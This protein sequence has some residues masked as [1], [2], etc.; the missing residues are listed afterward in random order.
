VNK[1]SDILLRS[2]NAKKVIPAVDALS[3]DGGRKNISL[4]NSRSLLID[5]IRLTESL[6]VHIKNAVLFIRTL[7]CLV[8]LVLGGIRDGQKSLPGHGVRLHTR[9]NKSREFLQTSNFPLIWGLMARNAPV[10]STYDGDRAAIIICL[11]LLLVLKPGS[12]PCYGTLGFKMASTLRTQILNHLRTPLQNLS[13]L[14]IKL[15]LSQRLVGRSLEPL[16]I[17]VVV[18]NVAGYDLSRHANEVARS[19]RNHRKHL[20]ERLERVFIRGDG[21]VDLHNTLSKKK[22][23]LP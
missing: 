7:T 15:K 10:K 5:L 4:S 8:H 18:R 12:C 1:T 16:K 21:H 2:L 13:T 22:E 19:V 20:K 23:M 3:R 11:L 17:G 6:S 9:D 14:S